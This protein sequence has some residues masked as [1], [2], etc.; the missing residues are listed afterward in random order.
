MSVRVAALVVAC[1]LLSDAGLSGDV[2]EDVLALTGARTKIVWLHAVQPRTKGWDAVDPDYELVCF[3]TAD[4]KQRVILPG[5]ASYCN[6][7][8]SPDGERV[9]FSDM[10]TNTLWVINWDGSNRRELTKGYVLCTWRDP[11]DRNQWVYFTDA[12]YMKG[13]LTRCRID[14]PA[15]RE[16]VWSKEQAAHTLTLSA[17]GTHAGSE[18]PWPFAGV[19][20]LPNVSWKQYGN[21]CNACIAPDNSYRFFHMGEEVGHDG[22]IFY[23]D[24]GTNRRVISFR[25]DLHADSWV[26]RWTNDVRFLTTNSAIGGPEAD[27]YLGKFDDAFNK[28]EKWVRIT[29]NHEQDT[30]ACAWLDPGLGQFSGEAPFTVEIAANLTTGGQW[31]WDYGDGTAE[32]AAAGGGRASAHTYAKPGTY[33]ITA[34]SGGTVLKG[35]VN[36]RARKAPAMTDA[37]LFDES[38]LQVTFDERLE[39]TDAK[40]ALKSGVPIKRLALDSEGLGLVIELDGK[41]RKNDTLRLDGVRDRAQVPNVVKDAIPIVRP[42]WPANRAGLVF[43]W[44]TAKRQ[45]FQFDPSSQTFN[46]TDL[47]AWKQARLDRY[48]VMALD[49]GAFL[50]TDGGA[51]IVSECNKAGEFSVEATITPFNIH[52][53]HPQNPRR[54]FG[55]NREGG[56]FGDA[57]F[58]LCQEGANLV[59]LL[60]NQPPDSKDASGTISRVELCTLA[61]QAPNHVV[62]TYAPGKLACYLNGKPVKQTDEPRGKLNWLKP[63]FENGLHMGGREDVQ[64]TWRGRLEGIAVFSRALD[65]ADAANDFAICSKVLASRKAVPQIEVQAR[66][67]ALSEIPRP[68]DISPYRDALVVNEYEV[69][70]VLRGKYKAKKMRVAQWGL[71][72]TRPTFLAQAKVGDAVQMVVEAFSEHPELEAEASR[73]TLEEDLDLVLYAD[74]TLRPSGQPRLAAVTLHPAELWVPP[75]AKQQFSAEL[76]DQYGNP[77]NVPLTWSVIP[78]GQIDTGTAYGAGNNFDERKLAGGGTIDANGLFSSNGKPGVVTIVAAGAQDP[79][80]KG[81]AILAVGNWPPI[82]PAGRAPM[83]FGVENNDSRP[84]VGDIDRIRIYSRALP[85]GEIEKHAAG[86]GLDANDG[87]VGDWTFDELKNGAYANASG[88]GLD[89]KAFEQV[90]HVD[91]KDGK[92]VR[93]NGKGYLEV[94]PDP[95]L[96]FSKAGTLEAWVR[97]KGGCIIGKQIVWMWGFV[98]WAEQDGLGLDALRTNSGWLSGQC[99]FS[100]GAWT[101]VAGVFETCGS[102]RLYANGK[103]IGEKKPHALVIRD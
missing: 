14:D 49:G 45:H 28:V 59:L 13:P 75:N 70:K 1:L 53:G 22:V 90:E 3:D 91:D 6:P 2:R 97:P 39:L 43:L 20:I 93:L 100:P 83:R 76:R 51:G 8:I 34:R 82:H 17:D 58:A 31:E 55:C 89:A 56:G 29:N 50:A 19:A 68:A 15:I 73:S 102:W 46:K 52:Q 40:A 78:G 80:I 96:D 86:Q 87:L 77:I 37:H 10:A 5:P 84:F 60:R 54:I 38:H 48:G 65:A 24:G 69:T 44:E 66:V 36:I 63:R 7:C 72:D 81:F 85:A 99:K 25:A 92:Y 41:L 79:A 23:D 27:I 61:D 9:L 67:A 71:L 35:W 11:K 30:K 32:K 21:G 64:F 47:K 18:F 4:G 95:R 98:L 103:L 88:T 16:V 57:N 12:G 33:T 42:E 101:H 26:P 94:A 74:V 62:V